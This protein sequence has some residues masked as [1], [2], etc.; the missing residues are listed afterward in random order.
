[1]VPITSYNPPGVYG[2]ASKILA[3]P[4][5]PA[6]DG[7]HDWLGDGLT[8]GCK[9]CFLMISLGSNGESDLLRIAGASCS[10]FLAMEVMDS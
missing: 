7:P 1:M 3:R 8:R 10:D 4:S 6:P 2:F 5:G 9:K